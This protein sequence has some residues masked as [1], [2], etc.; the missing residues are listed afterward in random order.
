MV[1]SSP[2]GGNVI[3]AKAAATVTGYCMKCKT[4]REINNA[5]QIT[6]K[7][8]RPATA[9]NVLGMQHQDVQDRRQQVVRIKMP[10]AVS[11]TTASTDQ[12]FP[13]RLA[14]LRS[15]VLSG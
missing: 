7:N 14:R 3:M 10:S 6:M 1:G 13:G 5:K 9:R 15:L 2:L 11:R 12:T 4:Q 8:G